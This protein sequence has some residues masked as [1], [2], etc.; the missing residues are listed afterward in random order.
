MARALFDGREP[1]EA[2]S[3]EAT[4][5]RL[6]RLLEDIAPDYAKICCGTNLG[7]ALLKRHG[8]NVDLC[9]VAALKHYCT[10]LPADLYPCAI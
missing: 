1:G 9:V 4:W 3:A 7:D 8:R 2:K 10:V 5:S 6:D